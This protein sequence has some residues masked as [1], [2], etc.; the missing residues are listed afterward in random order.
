MMGTAASVGR[1]GPRSHGHLLLLASAFLFFMSPFSGRAAEPKAPEVPKAAAPPQPAVI[2][3]GDVATRSTELSNFLLTL[4]AQ[5]APSPEIETIR[6]RLSELR[7]QL[8]QGVSK[9]V[10]LLQEQP[11]LA[12]LQTQQEFWKGMQSQTNR[13]LKT[14]TERATH[15]REE[16][17]RVAQMEKT[18]SMT[19]EAAQA[20]KEAGAV[21]QQI[22]AS[23]AAIR[24]AQT[25]LQS[26]QAALLDLQGRV[27]QEVARCENVL[28]LI[29]RAQKGAVVGILSR[30]SPPIWSAEL[31]VRA[32]T[33]LQARLRA[34]VAN[35]SSDIRAYVGDPAMRMPLHAG[36]FMAVATLLVMMMRRARRDAG[37]VG[38]SRVAIVFERPYA[39]ALIFPLLLA[40]S[41]QLPVPLMLRTSFQVVCLLPVIRLT[42]PVVDPRLVPGLYALV[43]LYAL[44]TVREAFAGTP[45]LEQALLVLEMLGGMGVLAYALTLGN[46][47]RP[48]AQAVE[49]PRIGSLHTCA[50]F[51]AVLFGVALVTGALGYMRLARLLASGVLGS[52]VLGVE[53]YALLLVV[54]GVVALALETWPLRLLRM[55]EHHR[56]FL[57]RRILLLLGWAGMLA[58]A[59]RSLEYVGLFQPALSLGGALLAV[60][61]GGGSISFTLGEALEFLLTLWV[62]Y[63][64]SSL[65]RFVLEE[66][67]YPRVR[68]ARGLSYAVSS[69]LNYVILAVGFLLGLGALGMDLT[70]LTVLAG[71]FGVGIGF[72]LQSVVNN[73]VS[74][75]ILLFERPI[76]VG[77]AVEV[78]DLLG[79]VRRI[80]IRASTVRTYQ[81]AEIIVPNAQLV[82]EKVTNW[83]LSDQRR[84]IDLPV[85]VNYGAVPRKVIEVLQAVA[86]AH[87]KVLKT[88]APQG[89]F[90]GY[91][92]SSINFELRAWTDD[93]ANWYA[94]RSDLAAAVYDAV[95]DA[96][97]SFPFPQR[98]V[99]LLRDPEAGPAGVSQ[100]QVQGRLAEPRSD[101]GVR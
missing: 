37:D 8:E 25:P 39:A 95:K 67:V 9:T 35:F 22:D 93:F 15:L 97:I 78:G 4:N 52:G 29:T 94:I 57:A 1:S 99:R 45:L 42:R 62:A 76:H 69:L 17:E 77:D 30:N 3:V 54:G 43:I 40:S 53:L 88:P 27:A 101:K 20:S 92:D 59:M 65:I 47:R 13:W 7:A 61:L 90:T 26:E 49:P 64:F 72:G 28:E 41:P 100:P 11:A 85:G 32:Q 83:T 10:I 24:A 18:W 5:V 34:V 31:R 16:S 58:W 74:G 68:L 63:L 55:V 66:D 6:K 82:T 50:I 19:R 86:G 84:R 60:K 91:G 56:N 36:V 21:L 98:E 87:P 81:G 38:G 96:G 73:F 51:V 79:E 48:S 89:L 14:L 46:L 44:D 70:K 33:D 71:A 12:I 80:G 2:P 75:L 23:L